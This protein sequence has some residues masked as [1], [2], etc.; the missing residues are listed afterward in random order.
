MLDQDLILTLCRF[1]HYGPF[2]LVGG[3]VRDL[4]LDG[5]IRDYDFLLEGDVFALGR[6]L[7]TVLKGEVSINSDFL[8]V[9]IVT[10]RYN[11][12]IARARK[13]V[14]EK[15]AAL[16]KVS[17]ASWQED[18]ARRD[19]TVN[20]MAMPV[21]KRDWGPLIDPFGGERDLRQKMIRYL[22]KGS[23]RDDPTRIL[24]AIRFKNRLGFTIEE[25][26]LASLR[27][28][29]P[30]LTQVS[31]A[32]RF[33]EWKLLCEET[34]ISACLNDIYELGGWPFLFINV[35]FQ[36]E[37]TEEISAFQDF[38]NTRKIRLWFIYLLFLL[39]TQPDKLPALSNYWGISKRDEQE[40]AHTLSV[41]T[42][43]KT[44]PGLPERK[45]YHA[46]RDLPPEGIYF[47][48]YHLRE[49][50]GSWQ[51]FYEKVQ[52]AE[53]PL[54][55]KDLIRAGFKEGPEIGRLLI[56][57]KEAFFHGKFTTREEGLAYLRHYI[58]R[59]K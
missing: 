2:F 50:A 53:L 33:H 40:L 48:Y 26:T 3:S 47:C 29:W 51:E 25:G 4:L 41:L 45:I 56:T 15:P 17:P 20:A 30:Y 31:P 59:G 1:L 16:P 37:N 18:L 54:T 23:F 5:V 43:V 24:R 42:L 11:I 39:K 13:E 35:S 32:R 22:H 36:R 9:S 6:E 7:G 28:D 49:R 44:G 58:E 27:K 8:T 46:L 10:G 14:Y 52:A 57:L 12:D 38:P 19:F 21:R 34:R 55:G